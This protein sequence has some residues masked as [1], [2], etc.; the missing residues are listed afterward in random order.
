MPQCSAL[1]CK[2]RGIHLFPKDPK[3]RKQ[4]ETALRIKNFKATPTARLC[5]AHFKEEDYFGKSIYTGKK[6]QTKFIDFKLYSSSGDIYD[7][8]IL[9]N[10]LF[11]HR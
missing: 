7:C 1:N 6:Q 3:R 10:F 2:N 8:A 11:C 5:A 4:W 9:M